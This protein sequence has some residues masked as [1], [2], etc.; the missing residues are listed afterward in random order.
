MASL[1]R[2]F[3]K[4]ELKTDADIEASANQANYLIR[5]LRLAD[6]AKVRVFNGQDGEWQATLRREGR[7]VLLVPTI[8]TREQVSVPDLE[9]AFAPLKKTRTDFVIEKATELGVRTITPVLTQFTQTQRVRTDRLEALAI[10][11]AE[12]TERLDLPSISD[13]VKLSDWLADRQSDSTRDRPLIFC[14]ENGSG[15]GLIQSLSGMEPEPATV[16]IGPEGGFSEQERQM[17]R[18]APGVLPVSLG[19]R[20]LRA[21]TAAVAALSIWQS[22]LGDW[23]NAPYVAPEAERAGDTA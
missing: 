19:P 1:P 20:I 21:E 10:E 12:Q 18:R 4:A 17:L 11:A 13:A 2:V 16:L 3:V 22:C 9:L 8:Q 23:R 5:V 15:A 14:D 6:G 7:T